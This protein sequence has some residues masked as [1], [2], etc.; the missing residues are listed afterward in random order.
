MEN[1]LTSALKL[2][3]QAGFKVLSPI[4]ELTTGLSMSPDVDDTLNILYMDSETTGLSLFADEVIELGMILAKV[5]VKTGKIITVLDVYHG[6]R[7]PVGAEISE[8][9]TNVHGLT[10]DDV[11]GKELDLDYVNSMVERCD[12]ACSHNSGFDR[13]ILEKQIPK[14]KE[15]RF[16][17]SMAEVDWEFK[18]KKLDYLL[19]ELG[20][21][22]KAHR[23]LD[24]AWA[25]LWALNCS[26]SQG[27]PFMKTLVDTIDDEVIT[28]LA[29]KSPFSMKDYLYDCG[30]RFKDDNGKK[31]WYKTVTADELL[32]ELNMLR[33]EVYVGS[34]I[35]TEVQLDYF[36]RLDR[37]SKRVT[38]TKF[39]KIML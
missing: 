34:D 10:L 20:Y 25:G 35:K 33:D 28:I 31:Y 2:I 37:Y 26:N 22:F 4:P 17:C 27:V 15:V 38:N 29:L 8:S 21:H 39:L 1:A 30:Y 32:E 7:E 13:Q 24:D 16:T 36:N 9:S 19:M 6:F 12:L 23:A 18:T 14:L 11:Q 3:E 5:N